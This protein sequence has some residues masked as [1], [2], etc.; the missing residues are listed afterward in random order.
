MTL[1]KIGRIENWC[2][3]LGRPVRCRSYFGLATLQMKPRVSMIAIVLLESSGEEKEFFS[4]HSY[5][6]NLPAE[7]LVQIIGLTTV[8]C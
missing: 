5:Q 6:A 3:T 1:Q 8:K 2:R 7:F 4:S